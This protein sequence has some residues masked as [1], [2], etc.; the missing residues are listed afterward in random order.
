[1]QFQTETDRSVHEGLGLFDGREGLVGESILGSK[2]FR[3][4][5]EIVGLVRQEFVQLGEP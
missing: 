4:G 3:V 2:V 5:F 1:M